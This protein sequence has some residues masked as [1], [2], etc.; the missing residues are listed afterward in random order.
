MRIEADFLRSESLST[1]FA[2]FHGY[3]IFCVGGCVRNAFLGE[4][5][6]DIDLATSAT[7][8]QMREI[9]K[10]HDLRVIPT[11]EDHGTMTFI[12]NGVSYEATTY[13][14]DAKTDGRHATVMFGSKMKEDAQRR[15]FGMNALYADLNGNVLDPLGVK[16]DVINRRVRFIG[17]PKQRIRE[18]YLRIL[19]FFRFQAWYADP[20]DGPDAEGFAACSELS[21]GLLKISKERIGAEFAKIL[22]A[23]NPAQT[24]AT[25]DQ[26]GILS[27]ILPGASSEQLAPFIHFD[28]S[29]N[30]DWLH[31]L[32]ALN[33]ADA[34]SQLR[35]SKS[36]ATR[37]KRIQ[38]LILDGCSPFESGYSLGKSDGIAGHILRCLFVGTLVKELD[39]DTVKQGAKS[40]FPMRAKDLP[41]NLEGPEIGVALKKAEKAWL[42]SNGDLSF[43]ELIS[44]ALMND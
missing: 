22:S 26:C 39:L 41:E 12:V 24:I 20:N 3:E 14:Q 4:R 38:S 13:R 1:L 23:F 6:V 2:A 15:D 42:R 37:L 43:E 35:L 34:K 18:D 28:P 5:V 7:P 19:R 10:K 11:G 9:A 31:R 16:S 32:S 36:D 33:P 27:K 17:N 21:D 30:P 44:A 8:S 29:A 40:T 25:M